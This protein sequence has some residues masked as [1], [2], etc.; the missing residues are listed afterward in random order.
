VYVTAADT[1]G[2]NPNQ[3]LIHS[4]HGRGKF[5]DVELIVLRKKQSFHM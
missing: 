2:G 4:R 5:R 3:D 1:A